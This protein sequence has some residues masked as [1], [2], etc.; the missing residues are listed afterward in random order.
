V[1]SE[2]AL[3]ARRALRS[4][5][6]WISRGNPILL[7]D[8]IEFPIFWNIFSDVSE[9][10]EALEDFCKEIQGDMIMDPDSSPGNYSK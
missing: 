1:Y 7:K 6:N 8:I 3:S 4:G 10:N 5:G 9:T 2:A